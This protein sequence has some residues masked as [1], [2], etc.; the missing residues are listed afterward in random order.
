MLANQCKGCKKFSKKDLMVDGLCPACQAALAVAVAAPVVAP[1]VNE[2]EVL[3][4]GKRGV[5]NFQ[6][7]GAV[8]DAVDAGDVYRL[9]VLKNIFPVVFESSL[10]YVGKHRRDKIAGLAI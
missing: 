8:K 1:V 4:G 9:V 6:M 3:A 2:E 5:S 7:I 10:K